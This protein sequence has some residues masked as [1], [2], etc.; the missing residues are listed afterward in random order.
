MVFVTLEVVQIV[1][2][3]LLSMYNFVV[4]A[5]PL[6]LN[7]VTAVQGFVGLGTCVTVRTDPHVCDCPSAGP[8]TRW[9]LSRHYH[10]ERARSS[11]SD[12]RDQEGPQHGAGPVL[13]R[14]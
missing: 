3:T 4:N 6:Q 13:V 7:F 1:M 5:E 2:E 12:G 9:P 11:L 8:R 14:G 10:P